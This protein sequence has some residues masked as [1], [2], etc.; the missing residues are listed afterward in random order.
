M[1]PWEGRNLVHKLKRHAAPLAGSTSYET[2]LRECAAGRV[3]GISGIYANEAAQMRV[4]AHRIVR[5]R[6][7]ADDVIHEAFAQIL[8][9]AKDFDLARG[10]ARAWIYTIV[11][12]TALKLRLRRSCEIA[13]GQDGLDSLQEESLDVADAA[14]S[15]AEGVDVRACLEQLEPR[16]RASLILAIIDGHSHADIATYLGVPVGTVKGWIRRELIALRKRLG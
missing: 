15:V 1:E 2:A 3:S 11:R 12:N 16:R 14:S 8:R 5:D 9:D 7:Y 4:V 6:D 10:S 13:I